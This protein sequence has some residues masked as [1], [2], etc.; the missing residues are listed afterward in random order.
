MNA[1]ES[2]RMD[3]TEGYTQGQLDA[4]NAEWRERAEANGWEPGSDEY[5]EMEKAFADEVARR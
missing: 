5:K 1:Y 2:F 4:F 3:N